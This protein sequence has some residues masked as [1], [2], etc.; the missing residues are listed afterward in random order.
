MP[1]P[2]ERQPQADSKRRS[3][4]K[5]QFQTPINIGADRQ[6]FVDDFW[7]VR[8]TGVER[9]LHRPVRQGVVLEP[10]HPWEAG[11]LSYLTIFPDEGKIRG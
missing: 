5:F 1:A 10:E 7:V 2:L 6:L 3:D 11:G 4:A 9:V 8:S